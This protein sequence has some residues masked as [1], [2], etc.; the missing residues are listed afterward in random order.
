MMKIETAI[1]QA[2]RE[3]KSSEQ[4]FLEMKREKLVE[5]ET[6]VNCSV[7]LPV[8]RLITDYAERAIEMTEV[9]P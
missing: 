5:R 7:N 4:F 3:I 1:K 8:M 9:K 6:E 2:K